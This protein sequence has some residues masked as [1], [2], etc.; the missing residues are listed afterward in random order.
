MPRFKAP[1]ALQV[2]ALL[3]VVYAALYWGSNYL[4]WGRLFP[5]SKVDPLANPTRVVSWDST[6][7]YLADGRTVMP[8]GMTQLPAKSATM[9][10][11][12]REGVEVAPDGRV[13]GLVKIW[14]WCGNDPVRNDLNRTDIAQLLAYHR[15][16]TSTLKPQEYAERGFVAMGGGTERGWFQSSHIRMKRIFDSELWSEFESIMDPC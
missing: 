13:F 11:A 2:V 8:A 7:L 15:E 6:G 12:I 1:I 4:M 9:D 14:H 10:I 5:I 3:T 16:G